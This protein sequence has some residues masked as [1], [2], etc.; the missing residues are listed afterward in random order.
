MNR[1]ATSTLVFIST[2]LMVSAGIVFVVQAQTIPPSGTLQIT[3]TAYDDF[4]PPNPPAPPPPGTP[5]PPP[6]PPP[7]PSAGPDT[8][9]WFLISGYPSPTNPWIPVSTQT[10]GNPPGTG[11]GNITLAAGTYDVFEQ[12]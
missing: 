11:Q 9:F 4:F 3:K 5:P 2:L 8:V 1:K 7:I 10:S 12:F 6:A